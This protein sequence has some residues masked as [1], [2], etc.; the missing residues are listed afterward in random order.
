ML[1]TKEKSIANLLPT[2]NPARENPMNAQLAAAPVTRFTKHKLDTHLQPVTSG[3]VIVHNETLGFYETVN[4][5]GFEKRMNDAEADAAITKLN[6]NNYLGFSDWQR[7]APWY[8]LTQVEY[9]DQ[10]VMADLDLYPDMQSRAYWTD[11]VVSWNTSCVFAVDFGYGG[12]YNCHR[13]TKCF[14]RP[15]RVARQ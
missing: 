2:P 15:V 12:V 14:V 6:A 9:S 3:H 13:I 4:A 7:P 11:Q 10:G 8:A 1:L 5:P